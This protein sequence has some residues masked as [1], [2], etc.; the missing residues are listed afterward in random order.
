M[1]CANVMKRDRTAV[2]NPLVTCQPMGAMYAVAGIRRG[3]PLVHGSQGCSTFVR[4]SFSRHFREP[5]EIAVTS[6]HEDA[7]VFGG[8]KNLIS[9]IGNLAVRFKPSVIGAISTCSS[10][11]I[12]DD[13]EGFIKIARED[14]KKKMGEKEAGKI[15]IVPISTPSF[16]ENHF[17]GYDN[18]IKALV[19]NLAQ[20][21]GDANEKINMIPGMVNPGDVREIKHIMSLMG[22]EGI[23]L[24]DI[25]D[26]FDS[27]LRPSATETRPFYPKGGTTVEEIADSSNSLGTISL[28]GYAGSGALSLEKKYDVPA[29]VGP[30]PIGVQNTD[31]FLRNLKKFTDLEIPDSILDERG[32]L[33]DSMADLASRY[34]FGRKVAIFGDPAISAGIARFVCE[35][36]MIPSV[37]CTGVENPEFVSEMEKVAKESDEPVDV[38]IGSDL[39]ALEV[40][41]DEDPVELMIGHSDGRLFAKH[42]NIPLV[43]VGYPVYDRAGYHRVPIVGYN[44]SVNLIDRITNTVFEKY[45]DKEH[46]KLQQ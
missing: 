10:E 39:R 28:C 6:L 33:I 40:R 41:L 7:A 14:L 30:I 32:L 22:V 36:G 17:R 5:S 23:V 20:D 43:R 9:G 24:T 37:V 1:S 34:L 25:S 2:I 26:P 13:M 45:Y 3:L 27:P 42:L 38:M 46:W 4:Y 19:T 16:V 15:K 29:A 31:Q 21:P 8:R 35:L 44:G 18:A 12:G 11:I